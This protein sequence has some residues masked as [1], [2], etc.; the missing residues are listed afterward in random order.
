[1]CKSL[2]NSPT[3]P[4][5]SRQEKG[6]INPPECRVWR[7]LHPCLPENDCRVTFFPT[8]HRTRCPCSVRKGHCILTDRFM[9]HSR[10]TAPSG[11]R[12]ETIWSGSPLKQNA[13]PITVTYWLKCLLWIDTQIYPLCYIP[14]LLRNSWLNFYKYSQ[15]IPIYVGNTLRFFQ[16]WDHKVYI[17]RTFGPILCG[18]RTI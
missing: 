7:Q 16:L 11:L 15:Q 8:E 18:K 3:I 5:Y 4:V 6:W 9:E 13:G 14:L 1:M 17:M 12:V 2:F 10:S